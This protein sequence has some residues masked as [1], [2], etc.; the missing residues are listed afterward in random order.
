[1]LFIGGRKVEA[2]LSEGEGNAEAAKGCEA[3]EIVIF[4][5]KSE[6]LAGIGYGC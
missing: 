5:W 1:M 2:A 4:E 6:G 3:L